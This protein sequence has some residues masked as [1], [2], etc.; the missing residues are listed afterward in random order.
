MAPAVDMAPL[1]AAADM[2]STG[3]RYVLRPNDQDSVV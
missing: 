3:T 1:P 2:G